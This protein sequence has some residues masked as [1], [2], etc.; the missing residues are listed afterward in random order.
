MYILLFIQV[1]LMIWLLTILST[2]LYYDKQLEEKAKFPI[3]FYGIII[4]TS[5]IPIIGIMGLVILIYSL[6]NSLN[7]MD[8]YYKPGWFIKLLTKEI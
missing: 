5:L 7:Q 8:V 6:F 1:V 3:W 2:K 4:L